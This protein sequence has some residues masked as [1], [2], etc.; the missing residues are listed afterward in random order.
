MNTR[1]STYFFGFPVDM[2]DIDEGKVKEGKLSV[3]QTK[4]F[5]KYQIRRRNCC[6][7]PEE[8]KVG[9]RVEVR[10]EDIDGP[11]SSTRWSVGVVSPSST[12]L[13]PLPLLLTQK[14][15][16]GNGRFVVSHS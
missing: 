10:R 7:N 6:P 5:F 14:G 3:T 12:R 2:V 16:G 9:S 8:T 4:V 15:G 11:E 13:T 1:D